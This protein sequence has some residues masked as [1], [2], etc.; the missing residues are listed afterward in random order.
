MLTTGS[1][2]RT[3]KWLRQLKRATLIHHSSMYY[4][5]LNITTEYISLTFSSTIQ[6]SNLLENIEVVVSIYHTSSDDNT[7]IIL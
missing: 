7:K 1:R 2:T 3:N 5:R 6:Y 4:V